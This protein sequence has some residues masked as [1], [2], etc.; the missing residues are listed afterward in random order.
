MTELHDALK[1]GRCV[2]DG[3]MGSALIELGLPTGVP[4]ER[5][6]RD[7]P[8][9]IQSLHLEYLDAGARV[10]TTNTFGGNPIRLADAGE[11]P[12]SIALNTDA[13]II[14]RHASLSQSPAAAVAL[15]IGPIGRTI[16]PVGKATLDDASTAFESQL[17]HA[18]AAGKPDL[19]LIETMYDAREAAVALACAKSV[20]PGTPVAVTLTFSKTPRGFH[21]VMGD[22]AAECARRFQELGADMVGANCSLG[23][24]DMIELAAVLRDVTNAPIL[25]QANA[26]VPHSTPAGPRY[27]QTPEEFA[28]HALR[29]FEI[30]VNAVGGCCG[31]TPDFTRAIAAQLHDEG[32]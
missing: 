29:L 8:N 4:P 20:L 13:M 18:A 26:G 30:G 21:T 6:N 2:F 10:I 15:S 16:A 1:G 19:V 27:D 7:R 17:T 28:A 23:S 24:G 25:C 9:I 11:G 32:R 5:W 14:A 12:E 22:T 3:A 31:T